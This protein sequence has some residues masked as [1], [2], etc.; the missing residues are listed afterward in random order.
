MPEFALP[1][2]VPANQF[3]PSFG[4]HISKISINF[5]VPDNWQ[6]NLNKCFEDKEV[7]WNLV[8]WDINIGYNMIDEDTNMECNCNDKIIFLFFF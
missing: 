5:S 2:G 1:F 3:S 6:S 7:K 8:V 4:E